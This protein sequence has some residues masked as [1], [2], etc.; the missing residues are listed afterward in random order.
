MNELGIAIS[1][2]GEGS[3][4]TECDAEVLAGNGNKAPRIPKPMK[5]NGKNTWSPRSEEHTSELQ[6]LS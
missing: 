5:S 2:V 6:S 1:P 4:L 3:I